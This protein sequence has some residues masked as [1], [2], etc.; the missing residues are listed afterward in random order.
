MVAKHG[1]ISSPFLAIRVMKQPA[2]DEGK[3]FPLAVEI[4]AKE[5]YMDDTLS[6]RHSLKEALEKQQDLI[7]I[8]KVVGFSLHKWKANHPAL[9][10]FPESVCAKI[11]S[12][13]LYFT[14]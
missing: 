9:L 11:S 1:M 2:L 4:L 13:N 10:N 14:F 6:G 3:N 8:C 5:T 12:S 7:K